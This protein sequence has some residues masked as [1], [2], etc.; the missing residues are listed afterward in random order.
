MFARFFGGEHE[1]V[2]T[3]GSFEDH[4]VGYFGWIDYENMK[5][6][7]EEL[8]E[9]KAF[10]SKE[11]GTFDGAGNAELFDTDPRPKD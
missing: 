4:I 7:Y 2:E 10:I 8:L 6:A 9:I 11:L 1:I 3:A 5:A